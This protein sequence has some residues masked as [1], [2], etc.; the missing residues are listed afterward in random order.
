MISIDIYVVIKPTKEPHHRGSSCP[1]LPASCDWAQSGSGSAPW[2]LYGALVGGP[3]EDDIYVDDRGDYIA[4]EVAT[5]YNAGFQSLVA[6]IKCKWMGKKC[7]SAG[8]T[9][10]A[11]KF[12]VPDSEIKHIVH[13]PVDN[14]DAS[15]EKSKPN[16]LAKPVDINVVRDGGNEKF[17]EPGF[18]QGGSNWECQG[19]KAAP[20]WEKRDGQK[21]MKISDRQGV[22]AGPAQTF[23][24]GTDLLSNN[25]YKAAIWVKPIGAD[26]KKEK[27]TM[28]LKVRAHLFLSGY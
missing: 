28:T 14:T 16:T 1:G 8:L 10:T 24:Y 19:C 27:Y 17:K 15:A 4:N 11:I 3:D 20:G 12:D 9:A 2:V 25:E 21:S 18:E 26:S 5:D 23:K 7:N 6:G 22:W 13:S